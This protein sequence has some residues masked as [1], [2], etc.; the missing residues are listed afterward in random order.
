MNA[1]K[2][3]EL[4]AKGIALIEAYRQ[5]L[6]S[7]SPA[8]KAIYDLVEKQKS[9]AAVSEAELKAVEDVLDAQLMAFN[10]PLPE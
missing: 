7:L 4:V 3:L 1:E 10:A 2:V 5:T 6:E 8:I 9:G